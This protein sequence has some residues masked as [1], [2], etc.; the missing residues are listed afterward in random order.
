[1]TTKLKKILGYL[2]TIVIVV[3]SLWLAAKDIN[4]TKFW[5][6]LKEA[7]YLFILLPVPVILISHWI[8]AVRWKTMLEPA[9]KKR[10]PSLSYLFSAV[11]IGYA[12]NCVITRLGEFLRP[13]VYARQEKVSYSTVL[14]TIVVE[15]FIDLFVVIFMFLIALLFSGDKLLNIFPEIDTKSIIIIAAAFLGILLI[16]FYPP[17]FRIVLKKLIKPVSEKLYDKLN[18]L[19]I[20]FH[21]GFA[22]LKTKSQYFK[23]S[24]ESAE[25]W[26]LYSLSLY[27]MFF[28]FDFQSE[29][30]LGFMAGIILI[31]ISGMG[32]AIAPSPGA[33]GVYHL[34]ITQILVNLYGVDKEEAFAF[35]TVAHLVNYV[36]QLGLGGIY[37]LKEN[38]NNVKEITEN[39]TED[40]G[41][42]I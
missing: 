28:A 40:Q 9:L 26:L 37:F 15:R 2:L 23:L 4:F 17:F 3:V 8:R 42:S 34:I 29:L 27:I 7:D 18:E 5:N 32:V 30:N 19:Y 1:M 22:V 33:I 16:S 25:I 13:Y 35:A 39:Q 24:L 6:I 31:A 36:I 41:N 21:N 10:S 11:M 12:V 20:N 38:I 14:A